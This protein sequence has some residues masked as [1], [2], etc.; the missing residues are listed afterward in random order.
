[1]ENDEPSKDVIC[2]ECKKKE[3]I[4]QNYPFLKM[5][6]GKYEKYK[7]ALKAKTWSDMKC[8]ESNEEFVNICLIA[9]S[10]SELE[11]DSD[12]DFEIEINH[13]EILIKVSKYINEFCLNLK[14]SLK[15]ISELKRENS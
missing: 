14:S 15:R 3:H 10:D 8:E 11:F 1:M 9:H 7:K 6:K 4:K 13:F 2:F 5:K 12:I